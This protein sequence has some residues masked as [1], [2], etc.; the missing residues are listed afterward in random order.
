[1]TTTT[2]DDINIDKPDDDID[3]ESDDESDDDDDVESEDVIYAFCPWT[4]FPGFGNG[5]GF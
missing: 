4:N 1:M 3:D 5:W 2:A